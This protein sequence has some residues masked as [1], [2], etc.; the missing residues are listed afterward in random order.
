MNDKLLEILV[1]CAS[2]NAVDLEMFDLLTEALSIT[3]KILFD[4]S[5][6]PIDLNKIDPSFLSQEKRIM[7]DLLKSDQWPEAVPAFLICDETDNDKFERAEGI[8][9]YL[10]MDLTGKK[11]LDFGCGEGHV[12]LKASETANFVV[13]YD[14]LPPVKE[15]TSNCLLTC[16]SIDIEKNGPYDVVILYDVL[17]HIKDSIPSESGPVTVL[18]YIKQFCHKDTK[19]Y[20]RCHS[21][22]SRHGS[23]LYKRLNKA[24]A[25]LY[26]SEED[27]RKMGVKMDFVRKY[28][29]P[30]NEQTNWFKQATFTK[31]SEDIVK[32]F[33]EFFFQKP[34]L[35]FD[36]VQFDKNF[37][38][39]FPEWQMSQS[40]NDY[41]L[42]RD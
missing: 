15:S 27:L 24:Y 16:K 7:F 33:I 17:D 12:A 14:I 35:K 29:F 20:V 37:E 23:H 19:L 36:D 3:N 5:K 21:W 4:E 6:E 38:G 39:K 11:V 32:N 41:V 22:M 34:E 1:K 18:K 26:F 8:I 2:K 10:G 9:D 25:H 42:K 13:G 31:I 30:V 28:C 40:F